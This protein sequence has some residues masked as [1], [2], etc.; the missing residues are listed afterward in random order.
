MVFQGVAASCLP[1]AG[2]SVFCSLP[3]RQLQRSS[4]QHRILAPNYRGVLGGLPMAGRGQTGKESRNPSPGGPTSVHAGAC[5]RL[6]GER[7]SC[8]LSLVT[9]VPRKKG[10]NKFSSILRIFHSCLLTKQSEAPV[11][12][13]VSQLLALGG[14][15]P[16][17]TRDLF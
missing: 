11:S 5:R 10:T 3:G 8:V 7:D 16:P 17:F 2:V 9:A 1:P 4:P 6:T 12:T 15:P 14:L 13:L